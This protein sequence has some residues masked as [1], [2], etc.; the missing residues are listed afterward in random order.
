MNQKEIQL[1]RSLVNQSNHPL[2]RLIYNHLPHQSNL[3][4]MKFK[5]V[6][7]QGMK[8]LINGIP[9]EIGTAKFAGHQPINVTGT[10]VYLTLKNKPRGVF[11]INSHFR[12]AV[13]LLLKKLS[14]TYPITI[15]SGDQDLSK[16]EF[17][18][19]IPNNIGLHFKQSPID[20]LNHIKNM[21]SQ[22]QRILMVGDG[23]NDAGALAQSDIG[24]AVSEDINV[25][26]PACDMI[27][28]ADQLSELNNYIQLSKTTR[29][30]VRW[31]LALSFTYNIIGL[32]FAVSGQLTP[33]VAAILMPLSSISV[34][35][36][37]TGCT[38]VAGRNI[39]TS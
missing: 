20:K 4:L 19:I 26:S 36:F 13:K 31:S 38:S 25:F 39:L 2:S 24:I 29:G 33:V 21:Q 1:I 15:L 10:L 28:K 9:I 23:L 8:A 5:A 30:I 35:A 34:V 12:K 16:S 6:P 3:P 22:G 17:E 14:H 37:V 32:Y 7:G 18:A 27:L 11:Q